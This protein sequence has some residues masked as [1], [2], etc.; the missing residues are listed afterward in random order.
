MFITNQAA[1][2]STAVPEPPRVRKAQLA[3]AFFL[4]PMA[5]YYILKPVRESLFLHSQGYQSFP[6]VHLVGFATLIAAQ[7]Y[8]APGQTLRRPPPRPRRL[9]PEDGQKWYGIIGAGCIPSLLRPQARTPG[10]PRLPRLVTLE[11]SI[12]IK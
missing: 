11:R 5:S 8:D 2:T 1:R 9:T 4:L 12:D 3:A 7:A 6:R 10:H